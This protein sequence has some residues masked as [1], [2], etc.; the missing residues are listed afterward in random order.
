MKGAVTM[1]KRILFQN[2][3][4]FCS[5]VIFE[6]LADIGGI[7]VVFN[8]IFSDSDTIFFMPKWLQVFIIVAGMC[9]CTYDMI[10]SA[11]N[12]IVFGCDGIFVPEN[13]GKG[14]EKKQYEVKLQYV[15]IAD[16]FIVETQK[17]SLNHNDCS[18]LPMPYIV[19]DCKNGGQKLINMY[20]YSK[21]R[22]KTILNEIILRAR[23]AGN[24]FTNKTGEEIY[25]DFV[26]AKK[27]LLQKMKEKRKNEK[28]RN[29]KNKK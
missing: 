3:W 26:F 6:L 7:W 9:F 17:D 22:F 15:D 18:A 5:I 20:W 1:K 10:K 29:K 14:I 13:W 28:S 12:R 8:T 23:S 19:I 11:R 24:D 27:E 16:I 21:K 25:N 4:Y 2:S